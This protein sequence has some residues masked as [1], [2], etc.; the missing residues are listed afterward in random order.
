LDKNDKGNGWAVEDM[1]ETNEQKFNIG[2]SYNPEMTEYT[3]PLVLS[4]SA[5][6]QVRIEKAEM[7]VKEIEYSST[8]VCVHPSV[9]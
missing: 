2:T 9:P 5:S 6:D 7:K 1:F 4:G 3:T 8:Q